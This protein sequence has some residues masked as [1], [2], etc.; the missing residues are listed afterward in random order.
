M[1]NFL[2]KIDSSLIKDIAASFQSAVVD[3]LVGKTI[4]AAKT[5]DIKNI[6]LS[7]GVSANKVLRENMA[8]EASKCGIKVF[9]PSPE[10]CTDNASMIASA[11]YFRFKNNEFSSLSLN[12]E[13]YLPL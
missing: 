12:P 3:V 8:M 6:V 7:G 10:L 11:G 2:R 5:E 1:L 13:A 4:E 9:L